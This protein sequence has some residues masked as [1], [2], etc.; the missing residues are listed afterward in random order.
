V[1]QGQTLDSVYRGTNWCTTR[2]YIEIPLWYIQD[3]H[4]TYTFRRGTL[5][6]FVTAMTTVCTTPLAPGCHKLQTVQRMVLD[7]RSP[8]P[9]TTLSH[10]AHPGHERQ[11][12]GTNGPN[13][14]TALTP[15]TA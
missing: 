5:P 11:V 13:S 15:P 8:A 10:L 4:A 1:R 3:I 14:P 6:L 2:G 12:Q 7:K 9:T